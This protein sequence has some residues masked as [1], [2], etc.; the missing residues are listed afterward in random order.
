LIGFGFL[1]LGGWLGGTV[2]FVYGMRVLGLV[3][4]PTVR[5]ISPMPHREKEMAQRG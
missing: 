2:V 3:K 1:T 5:A 4:E